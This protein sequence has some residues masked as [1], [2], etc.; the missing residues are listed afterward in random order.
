MVIYLFNTWEQLIEE[1]DQVL[2]GRQ[3]QWEDLEY[4]QYTLAVIHETLR[5]DSPI[6]F[7]QRI[8]YSDAEVQGFPIPKG[9]SNL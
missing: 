5:H 6:L 8:A 4:L 1:I 7:L 9:V 2:K 3:P